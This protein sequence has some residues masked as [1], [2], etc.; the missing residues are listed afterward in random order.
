MN[1]ISPASGVSAVTE[2]SAPDW[3]LVGLID[4]AAGGWFRNDTG[5]LIE[6]FAIRPDDVVVDV[7]CGDGGNTYFCGQQGAH[8]AFTDTEPARVAD[9]ERRARTSQARGVEGFVSDCN[10]IPLADGYASVVIC[11]EVLEHVPDPAQLVRELVRIGAPGARYLIS[12]PDPA[13][14]AVQR[15]LADESFFREPNHVR[16][17]SRADFMQLLLGH[18]LA[19]EK[20]QAYGFFWSVWWAF[21]WSCE[22]D[23]LGREHPALVGWSRAW[24]AMLR[25]PDGKRIKA[26]L[27]AAVPKSQLIIARKQA[28]LF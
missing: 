21:Y 28:V 7:G 11:T 1:D 20:M 24:I 6:G 22:A 8:V 3:E 2:L 25:S 16:V 9:T 19:I 26:A 27:D 15:K 10:P 4:A 23:G 18:G 14:E 12:V 17:F 13:S 5:E